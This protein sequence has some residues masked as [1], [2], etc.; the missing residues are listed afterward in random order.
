[1][2]EV[3]EPSEDHCFADGTLVETDKG[4]IA[5]EKLPDKGWVHS[6]NTIEVYENPRVT[7]SGVPVPVVKLTFSDGRA[8]IC[9]PDERFLIGPDEWCQAEDLVGRAVLC[10]QS[11]LAEQFRSSME[12]VIIYAA[13]IFNEKVSG[14][15]ERCGSFIKGRFPEGYHVHH[16]FSRSRNRISEL[17]CLT[18]PEHFGE[19]HGAEFGC[20]GRRFIR[21]AGIA[22]TKWHRK[23]ARTPAG[24][25]WHQEHG[26][27]TAVKTNK[28]R[29][30]LLCK[31]CGTKFS[32]PRRLRN[33]T[34]FCSP[35]CKQRDLRKRRKV[36]R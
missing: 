18:I 31:D 20:R 4:P 26:R 5:I 6:R 12:S 15:I 23:W 8:I 7:R 35:V 9:T 24:K 22:A 10:S 13:S 1:M 11:L 33:W 27:Q 16:K 14:Y 3:M 29:V 21:K 19:R 36:T 32:T 25:H 28:D 17:E 30:W 2:D 34:K